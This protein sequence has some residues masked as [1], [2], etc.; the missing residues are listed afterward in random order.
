M[1]L[2]ERLN[3]VLT[4]LTA[5]RSHAV[6]FKV[7]VDFT[8]NCILLAKPRSWH[9]NV[10]SNESQVT[11]LD[12]KSA[13]TETEWSPRTEFNKKT[14]NGTWQVKCDKLVAIFK[15]SLRYIDGYDS[16]PPTHQLLFFFSFS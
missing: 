1:F 12:S 6:L 8:S 7:R 9:V 15:R 3:K 5:E 14:L 11:S 16:Q 10:A 2:R 4:E 13:K